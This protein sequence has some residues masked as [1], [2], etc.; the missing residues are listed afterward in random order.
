M[1]RA[2]FRANFLKILEKADE[3]NDNI[4]FAKINVN[5]STLKGEDGESFDTIAVFIEQ[6]EKPYISFHITSYEDEECKEKVK[7]VLVLL[8]GFIEG[9]KEVI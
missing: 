6:Y 5:F 7:E 9:I 2:K 4:E 3:V 1:T 8:D